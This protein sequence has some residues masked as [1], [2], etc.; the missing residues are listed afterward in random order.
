MKII[1]NKINKYAKIPFRKYNNAGFD[2]FP[3]NINNESEYVIL[4]NETKLIPTGIRC[5]LPEG[6]YAQI[7]E[8]SSTGKRG[9][10]VSC[11]VIDEDYTG[12]WIISIFNSTNKIIYITEPS[13]FYKLDENNHIL[14]DINKALCQAI[15]HKY[16]PEIVIEEVDDL[17]FNDI[18]S[19]S[20]RKDKNGF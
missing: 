19:N 8:R 11:G 1:F 20:I 2:L 10:K 5:K 4:P 3:L 7:E 14:V 15:L 12:E 6:F 17:I 16:Y 9:I 13:N 18:T